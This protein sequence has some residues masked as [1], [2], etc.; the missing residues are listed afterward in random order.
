MS[1]K[2]ATVRQKVPNE[3][4]QEAIQ[5]AKSKKDVKSFDSTDR[6]FEE[7]DI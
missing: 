1:T 3:I 7:L 5:D 2:S 4:T 6:L